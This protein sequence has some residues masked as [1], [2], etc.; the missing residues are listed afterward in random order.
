MLLYQAMFLSIL[1]RSHGL[2][3]SRS[4]ISFSR[5]S[6]VIQKM[7]GFLLT[8]TSPFQKTTLTTH[9]THTSSL[10]SG[11][12][13][14][15]LGKKKSRSLG[16]K[17]PTLSFRIRYCAY[18]RQRQTPNNSGCRPPTENGRSVA[19]LHQTPSVESPLAPRIRRPVDPQ[20]GTHQA[21]KSRFRYFIK[22][23]SVPAELTFRVPPTRTLSAGFTAMTNLGNRPHTPGSAWFRLGIRGFTFGGPTGPYGGSSVMTPTPS[24]RGTVNGGVEL[25][26]NETLPPHAIKEAKLAYKYNLW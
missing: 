22:T 25:S 1:Q 8:K 4:S 15:I 17:L 14:G 5:S 18:I 3:A 13:R 10:V 9:T 2:T 20:K 16:S 26:R 19:G 23:P 12:A 7:L 6:R 24:D 21:R 11:S